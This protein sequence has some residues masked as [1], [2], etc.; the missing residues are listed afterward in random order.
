MYNMHVCLLAVQNLLSLMKKSV[1]NLLRRW[2]LRLHSS[3]P[4]MCFLIP[5]TP[6]SLSSWS[7]PIVQVH[8]WDC[9]WSETSSESTKTSVFWHWGVK[10]SLIECLLPI[11]YTCTLYMCLILPLIPPYIAS[12][13]C[14]SSE[15]CARE[16]ESFR[17]E[18]QEVYARGLKASARASLAA[19]WCV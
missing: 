13:L 8:Q 16:M 10:V 5:L 6:S 4:Q 2:V 3:H 11:W 7:S 19:D 9:P 14:S 12:F 17:S 18:F 15:F 1:W